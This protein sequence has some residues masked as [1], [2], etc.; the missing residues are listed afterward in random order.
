[1]KCKIIYLS[2]TGNTKRATEKVKNGINKSG[3]ECELLEIRDFTNTS[4]FNEFDFF[5]FMAPVHAFGVPTIFTR[6]LKTIP[7]I[8]GKYAFIGATGATNFGSFFSNV[9]KILIEKGFTS[10][11]KLSVYA[12]QTYTPLNSPGNEKYIYKDAELQKA[13]NF[14][15]NI[16]NEYNEIV[17]KKSKNPPKF[18]QI[19]GTSLFSMIANND[20]SLRMLLG[21]IKINKETCTKCKICLENCAWN[22]IEIDSKTSFPKRIKNKC[23]GCCACINLCPEGALWTSSTKGKERY[24][25]PSYK[26]YTKRS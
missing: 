6:F 14:G 12:P 8:N 26:G 15:I 3:H 18:T 9:N 10:I 22:A 4:E 5:G 25:E 24:C 20:T 23:G 19:I 11:A 2:L 17:L 7:R 21:T 16:F 1:M 13:Y